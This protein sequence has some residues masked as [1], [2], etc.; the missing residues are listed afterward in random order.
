MPDQRNIICDKEDAQIGDEI[1]FDGKTL[2]VMQLF[3]QGKDAKNS[4]YKHFIMCHKGVLGCE[5]IW[6]L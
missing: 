5:E 2:K 6:A 1:I 3:R 4:G